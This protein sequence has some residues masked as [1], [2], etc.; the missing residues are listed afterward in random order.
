MRLNGLRR[1]VSGAALTLALML[2]IT[3]AAQAQYR[4]YDDRYYR[5]DDQVRWSKE[6]TRDY[7]FKLGYHSGYMDAR[8]VWKDGYRANAKDMPGYRDNDNGWLAWMGYQSDYRSSYRSGYESGFRDSQASRTARYDKD[9]VARALGNDPHN[10]YRDDNYY[11]N[12]PYY[13]NRRS[14]DYRNGRYD[15]N[16]IYRVAQQNGYSEGF[17]AGQNDQARRRNYDYTD[18]NE[19]RN[20]MR[21]YRSEY[22]D[23]NLY[24]Q[25]FQQGF[26][27]GYDDG[28]RRRTSNT[29]WPF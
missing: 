23:R 2:G 17:K 3:A 7:A 22:G 15:R 8:R 19:F 26:Q 28:Y 21:G 29:R 9:D 20:G 12:D 1:M 4:N 6:R 14:D 11:D 13:R 24:R 16:D 10:V 27:R 25:A 5:N 18:T